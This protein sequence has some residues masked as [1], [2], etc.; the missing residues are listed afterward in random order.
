[1]GDEGGYVVFE[2]KPEELIKCN[3]SY[4]GKYLLHNLKR[5]DQSLPEKTPR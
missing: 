2:G 4:T 3:E 5:H 1:G